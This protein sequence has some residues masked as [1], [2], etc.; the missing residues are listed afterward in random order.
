MAT[1]ES[2]V[3]SAVPLFDDNGIRCNLPPGFGG[4]RTSPNPRIYL[5]RLEPTR[6][7]LETRLNRIRQFLPG[8]KLPDSKTFYRVAMES[9][10]TIKGSPALCNLMK[11]PRMHLV[12][13]QCP[14][15]GGRAH[16][17]Y[18]DN[19]IL[20]AVI[21]SYGD[22]FGKHSFVNY[23]QNK[24]ENKVIPVPE[25]N[26]QI[27]LDRMAEGPVVA[28][29]FP[30][31]L[32]GF[33]VDAD[34]EQMASLPQSNDGALILADPLIYGT[35]WSIYP[36]VL[37]RD[38]HVPVNDCAALWHG[39]SLHFCALVGLASFAHDGNLGDAHDE[40]SGGLLFLLQ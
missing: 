14:K 7:I 6:G 18:L 19:R 21:A 2:N 24:L 16:G 13:E 17:A 9:D 5:D 36:D 20:P 22:Q 29:L 40:H 32:Q 12:F 38:N 8:A 27:L 25:S 34:V 10:E 28:T 4:K 1:T 39:Y 31:C 35:G 3:G 23:L 30:A 11:G 33:S 37:G 26:T 15:I